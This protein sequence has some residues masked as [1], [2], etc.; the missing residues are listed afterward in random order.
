MPE[1]YASH[2][3]DQQIGVGDADIVSSLDLGK[4]FPS[5]FVKRAG[6][7]F[8]RNKEMRNCRPTLRGA[9]RHYAAEGAGNFE[10]DGFL[11]RLRVSGSW[12]GC[13]LHVRRKNLASGASAAHGRNID[14]KL[15]RKTPGLRRNS[16]ALR[17]RR[18]RNTGSS[19][20]RRCGLTLRS[21]PRRVRAGGRF[22]FCRRLFARSHNPSDR[23]SDLNIGPDL[24]GNSGEDT[25]GRRFNLHHSLIGF[26]FEERFPLGD[27]V[28]LLLPPG[29]ELTGFLRHL[30]S[31]HY[32]AEG[33]SVL[34]GEGLHDGL[35]SETPTRSVFAL[36]S[37]MSS[38]RAL[39]GASVSRVVGSGPFTVK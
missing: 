10:V 15:F 22:V 3:G 27:A 32:H 28:A 13:G 19:R 35:Q 39:G 36:A 33:H 25:V 37:I 9:L 24:T 31:R 12:R 23:P 16:R 8:S 21:S 34:F 20:N 1:Q 38:T 11:R 30:K 18:L 6:L 2:Q 14:T 29:N 5:I 4:D 7:D 17:R 26:D